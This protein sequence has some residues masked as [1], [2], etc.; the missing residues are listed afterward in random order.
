MPCDVEETGKTNTA[1]KV[2]EL[3]LPEGIPPLISLYIY[4]SGACNLACQHCWIVPRFQTEDN[5]GQ[6]I[7]LEYVKKA[8]REAK[9]LGLSS[10][11]LTGGEPTIHPQFRE[12]VSLIEKE[13]L[14]ITMETNGVLIDED[15]ARFLKG[16]PHFSF[17]SVSLDGAK[18]ETHDRMRGVVGSYRQ[19]V[20]GIKHLIAAGFRPQIICTLHRGNVSEMTDLID[21]AEN[22][23]CGS[24][25]FNLVQQIGR[26]QGFAAS[27]GLGIAEIIQINRHVETDIVPKCKIS[28][29]FDIPFAFFPI[30]K[31]LKGSLGKCGILNCTGPSV[32][33]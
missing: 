19:A 16:M 27:Q 30:H 1:L 24:V 33:R 6:H 29:Y 25:K 22:L 15:L 21:M 18:P 4:A 32:R 23:G 31:L 20:S 2:Q 12:I 8:I 7:K 17:V 28:I 14:N 9:P 13:K 5:N 10:V 3:E 26:G 11:K